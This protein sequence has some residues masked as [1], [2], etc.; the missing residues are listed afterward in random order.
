SLSALALWGRVVVDGRAAL[1]EAQR[2]ERAGRLERAI[3]AY[4][5]AARWWAPLAE[6]DDAALR[7]L[8]L[9]ARQAEMAR[10]F[11]LALIAER[12]RRR[13]L[14]STRTVFGLRDASTL[15]E[16]NASIA[17]LETLVLARRGEPQAADVQDSARA[18][19]AL[20]ASPPGPTPA[21]YRNALAFLCWSAVSVAFVVRVFDGH[22]RL[23]RAR[24]VRWGLAW[25][26]ATLA[27][28]LS[29]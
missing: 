3:V 14:L 12:E 18:A 24:A 28:W 15:R 1:H 6:H 27:W 16:A 26:L 4:G 7:R 25:L 5:H 21:S 10:D 11:E 22:G 17:R 13:A 2:E 29:W 9:H 19:A 8:E 23:R 20:A